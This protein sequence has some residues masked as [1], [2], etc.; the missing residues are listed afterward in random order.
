M[1]KRLFALFLALV[2]VL[3][4][5]AAVSFTSA[6][7]GEEKSEFPFI[8]VPND[9]WFTD[10]VHYC[11]ENGYMSGVSD[12]LFAPNTVTT[13][14]MFVM[15]IA[16]VAGAELSDYEGQSSFDDVP[17]GEWYSNAIEWAYQ[18]GI[19]SGKGNGSFGVADHVSREQVATFL[20]AFAKYMKY[21]VECNVDLRYY[22]ADADKISGWAEDAVKWA[23]DIGLIAG[24]KE[25]YL[26]PKGECTRAQIALMI[27]KFI[28]FYTSDCEHE[29]SKPDCTTGRTCT[30][31]GYTR[32]T[33][34][35]HTVGNGVCGRCGK[36]VFTNLNNKLI[37]YIEKNQTE[38][39]AIVKDALI[40]GVTILTSVEKT[41]MASTVKFCMAWQYEN[42]DLLELSFEVPYVGTY[43]NYEL[44]MY[45]KED[46]YSEGFL[47][48]YGG[49]NCNKFNKNVTLRMSG[50]YDDED[51]SDKPAWE[52]DATDLLDMGL[53][54]FNKTTM[55]T[56]LVGGVTLKD[57]GFKN[58]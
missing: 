4:T 48:G 26:S 17:V 51:K 5:V 37:Y 2:T 23:V 9:A 44:R 8:D 31:C 18:N 46:D 47:I 58:Y 27:K 29:W 1:K 11:F 14:A 7:D 39:G 54:S 19:S 16:K 28:E 6:A 45:F 55:G 12:T 56:P 35:G 20:S 34:L 41:S 32:G 24:V 30:K 43:Y 21:D 42:D 52:K 13:R 10:G 38:T 33:P 57:I 50:Y 25:G 15:I 53:R 22:H 36:E 49:F 40:D 3:S